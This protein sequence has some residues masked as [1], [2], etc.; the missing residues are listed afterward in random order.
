MQIDILFIYR[1]YDFSNNHIIVLHNQG[2][3]NN[4]K[5]NINI[6]GIFGLI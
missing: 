5:N 3:V 1:C 6:I 2:F 4:E